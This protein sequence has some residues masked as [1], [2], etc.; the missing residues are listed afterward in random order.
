ILFTVL[1]FRVLHHWAVYAVPVVFLLL[2]NSVHISVRYWLLMISFKMDKEMAK[3]MGYFELKFL[4]DVM[5]VLGLIV[6]VTAM[7]CYFI[8]FGFI[9]KAGLGVPAIVIYG[10]VFLLTILLGKLKETYLFYLFFIFSFLIAYLKV[11]L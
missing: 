7:V 2:Y 4:G 1:S 3:F 5:R 9:P 8:F 10:V 6:V 11:T